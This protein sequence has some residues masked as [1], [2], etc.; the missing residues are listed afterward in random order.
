MLFEARYYC[1]GVL[2]TEY[3]NSPTFDAVMQWL[4]RYSIE[5]PGQCIEPAYP[6]LVSVKDDPCFRTLSPFKYFDVEF[7]RDDFKV[8]Y[9][10]MSISDILA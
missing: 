2:K 3:I 8:T 7:T 1:R 9:D 6:R 10:G 5:Y 4:V